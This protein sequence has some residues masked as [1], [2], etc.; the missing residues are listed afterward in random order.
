[1]V[2]RFSALLYI[3][4]EERVPVDENHTNMVRFVSAE[5][6]TYRIVVRYLKEWVEDIRGSCGIYVPFRPQR[7]CKLKSTV[8]LP[9]KGLEIFKVRSSARHIALVNNHE[10]ESRFQ[11]L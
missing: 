1:M 6:R 8:Q 7:R 5:D 10:M 2:Q 11:S 9:Q 4:T 3:P